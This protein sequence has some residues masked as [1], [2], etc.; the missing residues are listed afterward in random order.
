MVSH[1]QSHLLKPV[2]Q[3]FPFDFLQVWSL[4][5]RVDNIHLG[6][7]WN[8]VH[9]H[10][11]YQ[12]RWVCLLLSSPSLRLETSWPTTP[13]LNSHN[14]SGLAEDS[15]VMHPCLC[16]TSWVWTAHKLPWTMTPSQLTYLQQQRAHFF[17]FH[18]LR[19]FFLMLNHNVTMCRDY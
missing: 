5:N 3:Y 10:R 19:I 16:L 2:S 12:N 8:I 18:C 13:E 1:Q 9:I 15:E 17:S 4:W 11:M 7:V 14:I 6:S